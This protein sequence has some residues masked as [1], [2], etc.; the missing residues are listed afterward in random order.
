MMEGIHLAFDWRLLGPETACAQAASFAAT[1][2]HEVANAN[3]K[4][5]RSAEATDLSPARIATERPLGRM[6]RATVNRTISLSGA[7]GLT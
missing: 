1:T 3:L 4:V 6:A 5:C 2:A 7:G